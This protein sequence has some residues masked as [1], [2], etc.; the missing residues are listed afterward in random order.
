MAVANEVEKR[1]LTNGTTEATQ[2][3]ILREGYFGS[4]PHFSRDYKQ[5]DFSQLK[6]HK[7]NISR[8]ETHS[9][10]VYH[11]REGE[12]AAAI[13]RTSTSD[14]RLHRRRI[15]DLLRSDC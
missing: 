14:R 12:N 8:E 9:S 5:T 11:S 3:P 10:A 2:I 1:R 6:R 7:A 13:R 15:P 4:S